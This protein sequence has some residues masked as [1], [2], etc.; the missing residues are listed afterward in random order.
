[1]TTAMQQLDVPFG[2][3]ARV[4]MDRYDLPVED[5]Q[6][7]RASIAR[8]AFL[9]EVEPFQKQIASVTSLAV[10]T[11]IQHEDGRMEVA[12][13]GLTDAMRKVVS[14]YQEQ[15]AVVKERYAR[16]LANV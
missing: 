14:H 11:Y 8:R 3:E 4:H 2:M 13:D 7:A 12:D 10:P 5:Y 15:I 16:M 9:E 6:L 1:M